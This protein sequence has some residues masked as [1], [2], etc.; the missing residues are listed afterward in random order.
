MKILLVE[1]D[2]QLATA[3]ETFLKIKNHQV[4]TVHDGEKAIDCI[5]SATYDLY[6]TD[7]NLPNVTGLDIAKYIRQKDKNSSIIIITASLEVNNFLEAYSNGCDEYLKKPF[8]LKELEVL[9]NKLSKDNQSDILQIDVNTSYNLKFKELFIDGIL[10]LLRK[11]EKRLL[12]I[13]LTTLGHSVK[14]ED[15]INFVWENEIREIYPLRQLV[16]ELR[17]KFP[18]AKDFIKTEVGVGYRFEN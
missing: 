1:D 16:S 4:E 9:V 2:F 15:I 14:N 6:I 18:H 10:V 7:I 11:K 3:I 5:D 12:H 17:N 13:L 8:H